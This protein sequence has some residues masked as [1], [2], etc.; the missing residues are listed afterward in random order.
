MEP[1]W[2]RVLEVLMFQNQYLNK[3]S[4]FIEYFK[5][6]MGA[7]GGKDSTPLFD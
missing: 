7:G 3:F 4:I 5:P 6:E 2:D 1:M